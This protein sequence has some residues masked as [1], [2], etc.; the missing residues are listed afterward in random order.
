MSLCPSPRAWILHGALLAFLAPSYAQ[1]PPAPKPPAPEKPADRPGDVV[2]LTEW[3]KLEGE[4]AKSAASD[5]ERVRKA[6]TDEMG[7]QGRAGLVAAGA[8]AAPMVLTALGK[9][10]DEAVR[11][12]LVGVL[13]EITQAAH[14]RLL[15]KELGSKSRDVRL[16]AMHRC[17]LFPDAGLREQA[18]PI[19][20][21]LVA[22]GDKADSDE[23][24]A[25]ALLATSTGSTA[26]LGA[27]HAAAV[28][29][30]N[31]RGVRIRA[32]LEGV[33]GPEASGVLLAM[34]RDSDLPTPNS[35]LLPKEDRQRVVACLN[36]LAGC[37]DKA[38]LPK[39]KAFLD[40]NDNTVRVAAIN[41]VRG[42]AQNQPPVADLSAFEAV[43][44]AK[45]LKGA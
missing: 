7:A 32:A 45:K 24:Y 23:R 41:A 44:L 16:Y 22:A 20:S 15:A 3:P 12:K 1:T 4:A 27:L 10:K 19:L 43:E 21:K 37:G 25:A 30:W 14:T 34:F 8:A 33:R 13:D 2:R 36:L 29:G 35:P 40:S 38:A 5:L 9:E 18:E 17:A 42:I 11:E 28:E 31:K 39:A 26:G 6:H